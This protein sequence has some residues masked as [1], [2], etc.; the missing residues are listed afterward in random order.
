MAGLRVYHM[1]DLARSN[2]R[3]AGKRRPILQM[4]MHGRA[5][6]AARDGANLNPERAGGHHTPSAE[7]SP[8]DCLQS[9]R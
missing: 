9:R 7:A 8:A 3:A 5:A 2:L 4:Q 6:A 1:D